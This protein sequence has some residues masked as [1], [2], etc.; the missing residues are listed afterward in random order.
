MSFESK[1]YNLW[2]NPY[3]VDLTGHIVLFIRITDIDGDEW[4]HVG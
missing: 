2:Q 1:V 4:R 3:D